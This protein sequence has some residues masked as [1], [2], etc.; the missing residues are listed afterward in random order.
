[1]KTSKKNKIRKVLAATIAAAMTIAP[2]VPAFA[3]DSSS[4]QVS[5]VASVSTKATTPYVKSDTTMDFTVTQG[6]T[7]AFRFEVIG[8]HANP[9]IA[10]G[11]GSVLRTEEVKKVVENGNDVYYFK[12]RA[13]GQP[14]QGS[15]VYTTLPGQKAVKHCTIHV[16]T[17]YVKSDTTMDFS[18]KQGNT[19]AFRFEV[20]GPQGLQPNIAAGNGNVL[21][22]E[23]V[24]K[25]VE[26]GNDVY[27][28]KV[29]AI[30]QPGEGSGVYTT[31]PGQAAVKHCTIHVDGPTYAL[32]CD[33]SNVNIPKDGTYTFKYTANGTYPGKMP[34]VDCADG[35][36]WIT[37]KDFL[38][39]NG[40]DVYYVTVTAKGEVGHKTTVTATVDGKVL[41]TSNVTIT[42]AAAPAQVTLD[43]SNYTF[44]DVGKTYNLLVKTTNNVKPTVVSKN[45]SVVTVGTPTWNASD[46]GYLVTLT[47]TGKGSTDIVASAGGASA[48]MHATVNQT[49]VTSQIVSTSITG[50]K[51]TGTYLFSAL[52]YDYC[53]YIK[54]QN[55][56]KPTVT[57]SN[58][59]VVTADAPIWFGEFRQDY[60]ST[61]TPKSYGEADV[62][63]KAGNSTVKIHVTVTNDRNKI[64]AARKA[65]ADEVNAMG[66]IGKWSCSTIAK[67]SGWVSAHGDEAVGDIIDDILA[68]QELGGSDDTRTQYY[69]EYNA[70]NTPWP[71]DPSFTLPADNFIIYQ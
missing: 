28:F 50:T 22:T 40:K 13:T 57:S 56:I 43:T 21:R 53:L 35:S 49:S 18:V 7:Y 2:T 67:E 48:T 70:N 32:T 64:T 62:T 25:V 41:C 8:T 29:R 23:E 55:N 69:V 20:V 65:I 44:S 15:G 14:G 10:A 71:L 54:T 12:V 51:S 66:K 36:L 11:N 9:S 61:L 24:K 5:S 6:Q 52:D 19:Y 42:Q 45:T 63:I 16:G 31:L 39:E 60:G 47:A 33:T 26:K 1:M 46:G 59:K 38:T 30:G 37:G 34:F 27:Y 3:A 68:Q 58:P 4:Q 17:P